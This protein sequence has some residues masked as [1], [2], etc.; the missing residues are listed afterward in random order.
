LLEVAA[1][2]VGIRHWNYSSNVPLNYVERQV[3]LQRCSPQPSAE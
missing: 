2:G 3:P 1:G